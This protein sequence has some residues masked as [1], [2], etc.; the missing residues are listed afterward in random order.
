VINLLNETFSPSIFG[1]EFSFPKTRGHY[2]GS[3]GGGSGQG[4]HVHRMKIDL[5]LLYPM[6]RPIRYLGWV[7]SRSRSLGIWRKGFCLLENGKLLWYRD[8]RMSVLKR[9]ILLKD[10][11]I[12]Y[13]SDD[14]AE[15]SETSA[16]LTVRSE[17]PQQTR[18]FM[19]KFN[20]KI[21][22]STWLSYLRAHEEWAHR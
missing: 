22:R 1:P 16:R 17:D 10:I 3:G 18:R 15:V 7:K 14:P 12:D 4:P 5:D 11:V 20:E 8:E 6:D 19:M 13:H 21:S 9:E 2:K